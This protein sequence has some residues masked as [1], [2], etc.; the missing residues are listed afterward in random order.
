AV[1][2]LFDAARGNGAR[3][4]LWEVNTSDHATVGHIYGR[5][6][7][8]QLS[9]RSV[10]V[11]GN[12]YG[13]SAG[14]AALLIFDLETGILLRQLD[15][16]SRAG[17]S[18]DNGLSAPVLQ[19]DAAGSARAAFA[20]DLQGQLWKF[21]LSDPDPARWSVAHAGAPLFRAA[22]DQPITGPPQLHPGMRDGRDLVLFGTGKFMEAADLT[23]TSIQA[24]Y[25][26]LDVPTLPAGGLAP[27]QLQEQQ[28]DSSTTD[29][30]SGQAVRTVTDR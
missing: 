22:A 29:P 4:A 14:T 27:A 13:S 28:I 26:V 11:T 7:M 6:I 15:V 5:P 30:V 17:A 19:Y 3:G 8:V 25:A 9:G 12:G 20:G 2:R 10:L 16:T 24:F 18:S 21:D 23:D 1:I